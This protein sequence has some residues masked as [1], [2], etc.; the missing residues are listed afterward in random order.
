M[1]SLGK[2]DP[3]DGC[4]WMT[5]RDYLKFFYVSSICYYNSQNFNNSVPDVQSVATRT[6]KS[7]FS[8][9]KFSLAADIDS[10]CVL[11]IYQIHAR[12]VDETMLGN[13]QYA[14][15]KV[16][17]ARFDDKT[18]NRDLVF[19]DGDYYDGQ[20][21]MLKMNSLKKGEYLIY[22]NAEWTPLHP[23]QKVI[24]SLYCPVET[25]IKRVKWGELGQKFE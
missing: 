19:V 4:F 7:N 10:D 9:F 17:L 13:Y 2:R 3:N 20:T 1:D 24:V 14:P 15:V 6:N 22:Y 25:E 12:H 5:F 11:S 18:K 16:V 8:A 23:V 21:T